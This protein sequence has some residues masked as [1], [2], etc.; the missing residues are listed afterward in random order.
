LRLDRV[1]I[2]AVDGE[3][4]RAAK[5]LPLARTPSHMAFSADSQFVFVTLQE[6]DAI[7][8]IRL[9]DQTLA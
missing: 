2:Y 4:F 9:A 6:S 8:A 3:D 1:D 5:R 7:A